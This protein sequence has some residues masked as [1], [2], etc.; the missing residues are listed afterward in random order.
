MHLN[1][2]NVMRRDGLHDKANL[3]SFK[4][5]HADI[6]ELPE[7]NIDWRHPYIR[8]KWIKT[9]KQV[10]S[11]LG[12]SIACNTKSQRAGVHRYGRV[13]IVV[14]A[15]WVPYVEKIHKDNLGRWASVTLKGD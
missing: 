4:D 12:I 6:I 14:T 7:T 15:R 1:R 11:K 9:I 10:W 5:V 8:D 3:Y 13:A 2:E